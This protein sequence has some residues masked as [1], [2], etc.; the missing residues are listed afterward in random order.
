MKNQISKWL[1]ILLPIALGVFLIGYTYDKFTPEQIEE[2]KAQ[3]QNANYWYILI[4]LF[5]GMLALFSRAYRWGFALQ[6]LGYKP[7]LSTNFM[8]VCIAYFMNMTI[9]RSGEVSR[10]LVL[11]KYEDV[12]FDKA[13]GTIIAERIVDFIFLLSFIALAILLQY[14]IFKKFVLDHL[15]VKQLGLLAFVVIAGFSI[16]LWLYKKSSNKWILALKAK[17]SGLMEGLQSVLSMKKK[18]W[19]IFHSFF[20]WC[21]Y[22]LMF[23]VTIFALPETSNLSFNAVLMAFITG[24]VAITVTNSGFGAYPFLI[25]KILLVYAVPETAGNAFGWIVW[26]SQTLM[27]VALGLLSF[28]IL[29]I[30]HKNK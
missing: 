11:K 14:D 15:S 27:I 19:F 7:K 13:F 4:S 3:F 28:L 17:L 5:F 9:P 10:A 6:P 30:L 12:P 26:T 16:A 25:S 29:P 8:A 22:I 2:I 1:S 20:I 23:Y 24:G 18:G 21:C